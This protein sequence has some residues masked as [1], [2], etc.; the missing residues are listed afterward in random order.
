MFRTNTSGISSVPLRAYPC[1]QDSC[2][3]KTFTF[4]PRHITSSKPVAEG[5]GARGA[6]APHG[7]NFCMEVR[8][9]PYKK[10]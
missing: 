9:D 2:K 10:G 7:E 8:G 3:E 1:P 4:K 6:M 5:G